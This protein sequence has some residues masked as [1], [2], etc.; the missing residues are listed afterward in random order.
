[1]SAKKKSPK[2]NTFIWNELVTTDDAGAKKFYTGLF[3]W[4]AAPFGKAAEGYTLFK[5]GEDNAGGM[6]KCPMPGM[7]AHWLPYVVVAD[8]D[9]TMAKAKKIGSKICAGPFDVPTVGRVAVIAD[10]QGAAI[11]IITPKR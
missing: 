8:V 2:T 7:P 4:K 10:P 9:K 3:G 5:Q 1:M 11:G 6:M